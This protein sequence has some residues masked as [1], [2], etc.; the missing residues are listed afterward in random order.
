VY[1]DG[2]EV[3]KH[4]GEI[5][6]CTIVYGV[7]VCLVG[8]VKNKLIKMHGVYNFKSVMKRNRGVALTETQFCRSNIVALHS[9]LLHISAV[10][11]SHN[12]HNPYIGSY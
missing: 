10:Y 6:D 1:E 3:P 11:I 9:V 5:K 2:T 7:C 12:R 4:V 8:L